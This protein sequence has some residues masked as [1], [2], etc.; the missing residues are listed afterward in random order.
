MEQSSTLP[1]SYTFLYTDGQNEYSIDFTQEELN[2][3]PTLKELKDEFL[4]SDEGIPAQGMPLGPSVIISQRFFIFIKEAIAVTPSSLR[5]TV[6]EI[7]AL[8]NA[9]KSLLNKYTISMDE[10]DSLKAVAEYLDFNMLPSFLI[11][12][13][14]LSEKDQFEGKTPEEIVKLI[15]QLPLLP[16]LK[17]FLER[18]IISLKIQARDREEVYLSAPF[19]RNSEMLSDIFTGQENP[20]EKIE[21]K[22]FDSTAI[23]QLQDFVEVYDHQLKKSQ[24]KEQAEEF[25]RYYIKD[26]QVEF[27]DL[28]VWFNIADFFYIP[29]LLNCIA[30]NIGTKLDI[31]DLIWR[32]LI[33]PD[34]V[35]ADLRYLEAYTPS[36]VSGMFEQSERPLPLFIDFCTKRLPITSLDPSI[37]EAP[38]L[39]MPNQKYIVIGN[40]IFDT[41][42]LNRRKII[43]IGNLPVGGFQYLKVAIDPNNQFLATMEE[44]ANAPDEN[45]IPVKIWDLK[46]LPTLPT[47]PQCTFGRYYSV[48]DDLKFNYSGN[49]MLLYFKDL[50]ADLWQIGD[51]PKLVGMFDN[52]SL[53]Y[54]LKG[55]L[56][57]SNGRLIAFKLGDIIIIKDNHTGTTVMKR[58]HPAHKDQY[59]MQLTPDG[60]FV[61][62]HDFKTITIWNA[63]VFFAFNNDPINSLPGIDIS[64]VT[65]NADTI[66]LSVIEFSED[67]KTF[68]LWASFSENGSSILKRYDIHGNKK[69]ISPLTLQLPRII[70]KALIDPSNHYLVMMETDGT[71]LKAYAYYFDP[72]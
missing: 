30:W 3:L 37:A 11:V 18:K 38:L 21:I 54:N 71:S 58:I 68:L 60:K 53:P 17:N 2:H 62:M 44:F 32:F 31:A 41:E 72:R 27:D 14:F 26:K 24:N 6:E 8:L 1:A 9:Y 55:T 33:N 16:Y 67:N 43:Q 45:F 28:L 19:V 10:I 66:M 36:V 34:A 15:E 20:E 57:S 59:D 4:Q 65:K 22:Q 47:F 7:E 52:M 39:F 12:I 49:N 40:E 69:V 13:R 35:L 42:A 5:E 64:N 23:A 70:K 29:F 51:Q 46:N 56:F 48:A 25:L 63:D 61:I 50:R